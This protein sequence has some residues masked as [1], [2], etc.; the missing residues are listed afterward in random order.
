MSQRCETEITQGKAVTF[1]IGVDQPILSFGRCNETRLLSLM[2]TIKL[3][4]DAA[5]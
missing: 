5:G 3:D 2:S 1:E 4:V